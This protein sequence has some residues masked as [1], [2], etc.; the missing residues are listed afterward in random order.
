MSAKVCTKCNKAIDGDALDFQGK[1]YHPTC[2]VCAVCNTRLAGTIYA[3]DDK[4]FCQSDYFKTYCKTCAKCH[5]YITSGGMLEAAGEHY[6][7]PCFSCEKCGVTFKDGDPFVVENGRP[8]CQ[9]CGG[10]FCA[11]CNGL[12]TSGTYN[13]FFE[14]KFHTYCHK[15]NVCGTDFNDSPV[16][17]HDNLLWCRADF[18]R[19]FPDINIQEVQQA[20]SSGTQTIENPPNSSSDGAG[21]S[22]DDFLSWD[23]REDEREKHL[24]WMLKE[25]E[26]RP[27][28]A[29]I[30][31]KVHSQP[32]GWFV[33][34]ANMD[35]SR[36]FA[37]PVLINKDLV[38]HFKILF[39]E[40]QYCLNVMER[41]FNSIEELIN[42]YRTHVIH[43][44]L[45]LGVPL[46]FPTLKADVKSF[47]ADLP[48]QH[49]EE[50]ASTF[51]AAGAQELIIGACNALETLYSVDPHKAEDLSMVRRVL[52]SAQAT[53]RMLKA[54]L[55][56]H[57]RLGK[58]KFENE[59]FYNEA[60][61]ALEAQTT[62]L[63][64][65][66][67]A[68]DAGMEEIVPISDAELDNVSLAPLEPTDP[69]GATITLGGSNATSHISFY[70]V[71]TTVLQWLREFWFASQLTDSD[72]K[73]TVDNFV[74]VT[75]M[76][77]PMRRPEVI[78]STFR[79]NKDLRRRAK[80]DGGLYFDSYLRF[81]HILFDFPHISA[82]FR[83][84]AKTSDEYM[85]IL[86]FKS[87]LTQQQKLRNTERV[88][89]HY[90]RL[91][92]QQSISAK[93]I[94]AS[95]DVFGASIGVTKEGSLTLFGFANF[96]ISEENA[97]FNPL[98]GVVYQD[99]NQPL[100]SYYINSSHNT[101]LEGDQLKSASST[102][103]YRKALQ[104]GCRCVELDLWDGPK[105]DPVIYHG[106][107]L[108]SKVRARDVLE[109]IAKHAFE[110][111]PFPLILSLENHLSLPQQKVFA[112]YCLEIFSD[113]IIPT[114]TEG[115]WE[116][117]P[118][119]LPS[120]FALRNKILIKNKAI[121]SRGEAD[122]KKIA[123]E[124][125]DLVV[126]TKAV[127]FESLKQAHKDTRCYEMSSVPEKKAFKLARSNGKEYSELVQARLNRTYPDGMRFDSSN[128]DPQTFWNIGCHMVALNFQTPDRAMQLNEG[129]F[130]QN[131]TCG[132]VLKPALLRSATPPTTE[133]VPCLTLTISLL[134][135]IQ[136]AHPRGKR[137]A[138]DPYVEMEVIGLNNQVAQ[139]SIQHKVIDGCTWDETFQFA[140]FMPDG[141]LLRFVV[142]DEK[143]G[144]KDPLGF[145]VVP[146]ESLQQGYRHIPIKRV[147]AFMHA[148]TLD[149][150]SLFVNIAMSPGK[151]QK[152][153]N[154]SGSVENIAKLGSTQSIPSGSN[155]Q[156]GSETNL[157]SV[158][159]SGTLTAKD[160]AI[161][162][163]GG[164][165][166]SSVAPVPSLT[167]E[168]L[169]R[170]SIAPA[171]AEMRRATA[172]PEDTRIK[173]PED[174]TRNQ[175]IRLH[176]E[177]PAPSEETPADSP[178]D[179]PA[180]TPAA[181]EEPVE[182]A[183]SVEEAAPVPQSSSPA[184]PV[185]EP[186]V[187]PAVSEP[188]V[189]RASMSSASPSTPSTPTAATA[190]APVLDK[191]QLKEQEKQNKIREKEEKEAAKKKEKDDKIAA[192]QK[193]KDDK[194]AAKKK[195]KDD[196]E[197]AKQKA[198]DD[199][200]AAK[201]K[202]KDDKE[203]AK[204]KE[205]DEKEQKEVARKEERERRKSIKKE[206]GK[207]PA[208]AAEPSEDAPP[209]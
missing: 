197:A 91:S 61:K 81:I 118:A 44:K 2:L 166:R 155:S 157:P 79:E 36:D 95:T 174:L 162:N 189:T 146:I 161:A 9:A 99:M 164:S 125:S 114:A 52:A 87:F 200:E 152:R 186:V 73:M 103:P 59:D 170:G 41:R 105:G 24:N 108:T 149:H 83:R 104:S 124:L 35:R 19:A 187:A 121:A 127:T 84:Y 74:K 168:A 58:T 192:K 135:G 112:Q 66:V 107:T 102:E 22:F 111:S 159:P 120:P 76:T 113:K 65:Q 177:A 88:L 126:Y 199:K 48:V 144:P 8:V 203:A 17:F 167:S 1:L 165:R 176:I 181:V 137:R 57:Q 4:L 169:R 173:L 7:S 191:K 119:T 154:I 53:L 26:L 131:G 141:A 90:Y 14:H 132:Y 69:T 16:I 147:H 54:V 172:M 67:A 163:G 122:S 139:S 43:E 51:Q 151:P 45:M 194:E 136:L 204:Q 13:V 148:E 39:V 62:L 134:A 50:Y 160:F 33:Y 190:A 18:Q 77:L 109:T 6:H 193:E 10:L 198:K 11:I 180:D 30:L 202:E 78:Y 106:Y 93:D 40:G 156:S 129:K 82:L 29:E 34:R 117:N 140:V 60:I 75:E 195:E 153:E 209:S 28:E 72:G 96:L 94:K 55:A 110:K 86:E 179:T 115:F 184:P 71:N 101:Y 116:S 143:L 70:L 89:R 142:F 85:T 123:K 183:A 138:L 5:Q 97:P 12:I 207:A 23:N 98:H 128:Y 150:C 64:A 205:K 80:K 196:K 92:S 47:P 15:C 56:D 21:T 145:F 188:D 175:S 133:E 130:M 201:Q 208:A 32:G 20:P 31:L 46:E 37:L 206:K 185:A 63:A 100:Q 38:K 25:V 68:Q 182:E 42:Y 158:S 49:H 3:K 171:P 27:I 178:A